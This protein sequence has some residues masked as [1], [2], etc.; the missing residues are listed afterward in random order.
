VDDP[1]E[2]VKTFVTNYKNKYNIIPDALAATAYDAAK[3]MFDAIR[4]ANSLD[5]TAIRDA[6]AQTKDFP[7][8]TG[9]VNFNAQRDSVKPIVMIK[10]Q[11][12]GT[13]G[14][15]ERVTPDGAVI[16]GAAATATATASPGMTTTTTTTTTTASPSMTASP[17]MSA[18]PS[19]SA[20]PM[21]A[22][23]PAATT[24]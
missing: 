24:P 5:G 13:Y 7:G 12:G 10:I 4:R 16:P 20:S 8:V 14:V 15:A 23:T 6:L 9:V 1:D 17:M 3:I 2:K 18:S 19:M 21:G 22:T 11:E